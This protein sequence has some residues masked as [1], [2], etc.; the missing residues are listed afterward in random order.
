MVVVVVEVQIFTRKQNEKH[1]FLSFIAD[2][3]E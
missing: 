2:K 1:N 3:Q